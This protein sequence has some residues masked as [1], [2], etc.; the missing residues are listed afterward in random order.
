ML[1]ALDTRE[2]KSYPPGIEGDMSRH[3]VIYDGE[4]WSDYGVIIGPTA[5]FIED[6]WQQ[7]YGDTDIKCMPDINVFGTVE[8]NDT[9]VV[10]FT[11][12][13]D[14]KPID[15]WKLIRGGSERVEISVNYGDIEFDGLLY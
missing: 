12:G 13:F 6:E 10:Q 7:Q 11:S 4:G 15:V 2:D 1:I 9:I 3:G 14:G 8:N 5:G